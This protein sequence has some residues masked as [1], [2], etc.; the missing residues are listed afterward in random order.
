[1][2]S[3]TMPTAVSLSKWTSL[4]TKVASGLSLW[5]QTKAVM[6]SSHTFRPSF[7]LTTDV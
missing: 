1:M 3:H 5:A 6:V 7:G 2:K 4:S